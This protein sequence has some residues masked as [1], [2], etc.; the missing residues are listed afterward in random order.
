M[1]VEY[2]VIGKPAPRIDG[3]V[4]ATG[5]A[6]YAA[7]LI[8]PGML[9]AK[10]L[11]SPHPHARIVHIDTSRAERLPGVRA[12]VTGRDVVGGDKY[13]F[14]PTTRDELPFETEKVRY[15]GDEVAAVAAVDVDIA[16]EAVNL[17]RVEYELLKPVFDPEEAMRAD[18][19]LIHEHL[20]NNI[21]AQSHMHFGDVEKGFAESAEVREDKFSTQFTVHGFI[22][23]HAAVATWDSAGATLWASK[24]SPYISYRHISR[25]LGIPLGK[26]R[27]IQP[28]VG[29]GFGGKH[30]PFGTDFAALV[31][32]KKTGKPVKAVFDQEEVFLTGRRRH[33]MTLKIKMG[34]SSQG[35]IKAVQ[36]YIL[37]DGGAYASVSP[38]S[39]YLPGAMLPIPLH[40]ENMKYDGYRVYTNKAYAGAL[41]GHA[42]PQARFAF[43]QMVDVM[44]EAIGMDPLELR[45]RNAIQPGDTS[46]NGFKITTCRFTDALLTAAEAV[47]WHEKRGKHFAHGTKVRGVGIGCNPGLA[48]TRMGGHDGASAVL[49]VFE[50]GTVSLLG[51]FT[52]SGQ[53]ADTVMAMI[54]AETLGM[55]LAEIK[56]AHVDSDYTPMDPGTFGSRTTFCSGHAVLAAA[57]DLRRQFLD[58]ASEKLEANPDD[59][60]LREHK[61]FVRGTPDRGLPLLQVIRGIYYGQGKPILATG[62]TSV[63][64]DMPDYEGGVGNVSPAYSSGAQAVEVEVDT[65]TGQVSVI[66]M[67]IAHDCGQPINPLLLEGQKHGP[68]VSG[69]A[70]VLYENIPLDKGLPMVTN[71]LDYGMP[72]ALDVSKDVKTFHFDTPDPRGPY[73][74]KDAGEGA[75]IAA[76]PAI[77]N[78]IYDAIGVRI[79]ELPITPG[80]VLDALEQKCSKVR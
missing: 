16:E 50:D 17:I 3:E 63:G 32:A 55:D 2:A 26:L 65:Q 25:G 60:E 35:K 15:V 21:T 66:N 73:G 33:A 52:D 74:A 12:V 40:L 37:A 68:A 1:T 79:T 20:K 57:N 75:Q 31:L 38:L 76:L 51:G 49:K 36:L 29:G 4:K 28:Y 9:W 24:Q 30:E 80:R 23:P 27:I 19:P 47:G 18:A 8:L 44:A 69:L 13:G 71:F 22:E 45:V 5:R 10:V 41:I 70:Q 64:G 54:V 72:T 43:E 77:A 42:V 48:G 34:V 39:V 56:V 6:S 14:L 58:F 59:L 46:V 7:D 62:A 61:V 11:H 78:A 53:G 67:A